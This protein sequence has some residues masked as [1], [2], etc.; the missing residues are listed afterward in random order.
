MLLDYSYALNDP[1]QWQAAVSLTEAGWCA[2]ILQVENAGEI[3][4]AAPEGVEASTYTGP[5]FPPRQWRALYRLSHWSGFCRC[6]R[7]H[8]Q[9]WKPELIIANMLHAYS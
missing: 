2:K 5:T 4:S 3:R 1:P 6:V 9:L 8:I 7:R